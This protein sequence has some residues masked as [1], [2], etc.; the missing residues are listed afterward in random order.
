MNLGRIF[1]WFATLLVAGTIGVGLYLVGSP[2]EARLSA[3]DRK[4]VENL[5]QLEDS[6]QQFRVEKHRLPESLDEL[7]EMGYGSTQLTLD[8]ATKQPY[9]YQQVEGDQFELCAEFATDTT[10]DRHDPQG[11]LAPYRSHKVGR[12][13]YIRPGKN[14]Q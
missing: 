9:E 2:M 5:V 11:W 14:G 13:C 6:I 1:G 10:N 8:P 4:R 3:L 7:L 12:E